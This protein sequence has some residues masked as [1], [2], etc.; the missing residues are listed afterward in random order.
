MAAVVPSC[1]VGSASLKQEGAPRGMAAFPRFELWVT[2]AHLTDK[3]QNCERIVESIFVS[4]GAFLPQ[5]WMDRKRRGAARWRSSRSA[6]ASCSSS[7]SWDS[8]TSCSAVGSSP[9]EAEKRDRCEYDLNP[10]PHY[11][12]GKPI[13]NKDAKT[14]RDLRL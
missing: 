14:V 6:S 5:Q 4:L 8:S 11:L 10:Q 1:A 9:A 3:K 12:F 13:W 2:R 7:S